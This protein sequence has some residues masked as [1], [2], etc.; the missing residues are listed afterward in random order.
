[1]LRCQALRG[2]VVGLR[3]HS[4]RRRI[5][6]D[7]PNR[8]ASVVLQH[9]ADFVAGGFTCTTP[10]VRS[11]V[12]TDAMHQQAHLF[13][14][15]NQKRSHGHSILGEEVALDLQAHDERPVGDRCG[16]VDEPHLPAPSA[17]RGMRKVMTGT[18]TSCKLKPP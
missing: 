1:M 17:P 14:A 6:D 18:T 10:E 2:N 9:H 3:E 15:A 8:F 13:A 4:V 16:T 5:L 12:S 11:K 7:H